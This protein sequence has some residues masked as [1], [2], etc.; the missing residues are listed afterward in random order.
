GVQC[1][2]GVLL[3]IDGQQVLARNYYVNTWIDGAITLD[4]GRHDIVLGYFQ[5]SG[6]GGIRMR[7]R[8]PGQTTTIILPN[9]W[10]TPYSQVGALAGGGTVT[11]PTANAPLCAHVKA[12]GAQFGGTLSGVSGTWFAKS[13]NGLQSLAGGG[14][15]GFAGDV[16]V[17]AGILAFDTDELVDHAARLSVRAGA[18]LALAGTETV[19]ALTGDGILAI[20]GHVYVVPFEGDADCGISA[21]K[22]YTHLLDFPANGN[23]A[24]INGVTFVAAGMSGSSGD[25]TWSTVNPPTGTWN[26]PPN[27]STRTG[28]DRLLW[29]FIYGKD[30]FTTILSGLTPGK[31]YECRLYFR[32]FNNNPRRTTF[33]FTAGAHQVGEL[34]YNPDS[35]VKGSR[36]WMGCRYTADASGSLAIRVVSH[37]STDRCHFYGL[38]NE[39]LPSTAAPTLIVAPAA[40]AE[41]RFTGNVTGLG[42]LVKDGDGTQRFGGTIALP[43]PLTVQA[44]TAVLEQNANLPGGA[45]I[46]AGATLKAPLGGVTLG[47]ISGEGTFE[48]TGTADYAITNG[49]HFVKI[50]GD[51]DSGISRDKRYTHLLDFG[52][53]TALATVNGVTFNKERPANGPLCGY[54]WTNA[55]ATLSHSGGNKDNIGIPSSEDIYNLLYDF[56]YGGPY[57]PSVFALTGLTTGKWYEV[58]FYHR[59]WEA[60][61]TRNTTFTFDPDGAGPISDAISFNPD[62]P[63]GA[64]NDNYLAYRY[65]ALTDRLEITITCP[66]T[67]KYHLYGLSNEEVPDALGAATLALADDCVF[68]G[69][70]TGSGSLIK[71]GAGALTV[72]GVGDA[73]GALTVSGGAC[74]VAE[75]GRIT[76]GPVNVLAGATLFGHG[77]MGG[78]VNV[79]SNAWLQGG[80]AAACGTL[81]VGGDLTLAP[82]ASIAWRYAD[83]GTSD[84]ITVAGTANVPTNGLVQVASLTPGLMPPAKR[85]L[86]SSS[87]AINGPDDLSGWTVEG[88]EN[89]SLRYSDDRTKI[90]F[91]TPR[92]SLLLLQ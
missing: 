81:A 76:T 17:Q 72:T 13:G 41:A 4:A 45:A 48:L 85:P 67:H 22:T 80:T 36:S 51:A 37:V 68:S 26:D 40:A 55:P 71:S 70:V 21:D 14:V 89:A 56:C 83:G 60:N 63:A 66:T 59:K 11:L 24:T 77:Q 16:D 61:Q 78:P 5:M 28:I 82:G 15:N 49:P 53:S 75:G 65:F 91:F 7:V 2:D 25:Y 10:L 27:D 8:R 73:T 87:T 23:P 19:S 31:A 18:T 44:G 38:S 79:A 3:A 35:G 47:A 1:D 34:F 6:G 84:T 33:T 32:N 74:G 42:T 39:E 54:S 62:S 12:G 29:D 52:S 50:T 92:G 86:I 88:V 58:R 64:F 57:A 46:A 30:D 20:G 69:T 43:A 9:A 90:Y